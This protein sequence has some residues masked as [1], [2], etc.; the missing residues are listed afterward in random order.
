MPVAS[1]RSLATVL[2]SPLWPSRLKGWTRAKA[3]AVL[4]E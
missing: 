2:I 3:D 1:S 4:V